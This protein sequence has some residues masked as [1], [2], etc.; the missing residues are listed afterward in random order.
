MKKLYVINASDIAEA[1]MEGEGKFLHFVDF[2][3][4]NIE[5]VTISGTKGPNGEFNTIQVDTQIGSFYFQ[6]GNDFSNRN[7][8]GYI[9]FYTLGIAKEFKID[10]LQKFEYELKSKFRKADTE[11]N[12]FSNLFNNIKLLMEKDIKIQKVIC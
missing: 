11:L 1:N 4:R 9:A 8:N 10:M 2:A 6:D 7:A 5:E 12:Q 3:Y